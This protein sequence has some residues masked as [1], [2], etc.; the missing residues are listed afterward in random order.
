MTKK[1]NRNKK[2]SQKEDKVLNR[3]LDNL[4]WIL[5]IVRAKT[6]TSSRLYLVQGSGGVVRRTSTY[7]K[8]VVGVN[9][10]QE[11]D[12]D[13]IIL[14]T[15]IRKIVLLVVVLLRL[16]KMRKLSSVDEIKLRDDN[17]VVPAWVQHFGTE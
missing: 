6:T 5:G 14:N 2:K 1:K 17:S 10:I 11:V 9:I 4:M 7:V 3:I 13:D 16:Q 8:R 15:C 12:N